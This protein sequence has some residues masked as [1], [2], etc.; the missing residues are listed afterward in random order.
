MD[1]FVTVL[2]P[3]LSYIQPTEIQGLLIENTI[4]R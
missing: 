4:E 1:G 3:Q 2:K